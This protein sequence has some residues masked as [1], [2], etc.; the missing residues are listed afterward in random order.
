MNILHKTEHTKLN[1]IRIRMKHLLV[2]VNNTIYETYIV[3]L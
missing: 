2:F 1:T 3:N